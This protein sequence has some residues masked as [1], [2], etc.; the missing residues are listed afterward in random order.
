MELNW[1]TA[2]EHN[3]AYYQIEKSRDGENWDVIN[4]Q[5]AAGNSNEMRSY[6]FVDAHASAGNNLY[7]LS[8]FDI[9]GDSKTYSVVNVNCAAANAGYFSTHPNPS[10][11][12]FHVVLN[13]Q[14]LIGT[15]TIRMVDSRGTIVSQKEIEVMEGI[16]VYNFNEFKV[17]P[18]M[19]YITVVN[20]DK[21]TETIKQSIK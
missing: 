5:D 20:D 11:G 4:T 3:S 9:D 14:E 6:S 19:Y 2:S 8:Q 1:T 15:A 18:G 12:Q 7:R 16:N 10:T 17:A 13:N 21:S